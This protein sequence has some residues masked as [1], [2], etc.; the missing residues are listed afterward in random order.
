MARLVVDWLR[1]RNKVGSEGDTEFS[2]GVLL[3]SGLIAG[4]AIA[5]I[6]IA[7]LSLWPGVVEKIDLSSFVPGIAADNWTSVIAFALLFAALVFAGTRK[8]KAK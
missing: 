2:P 1:K 7:L 5:G 6:V 4:G 3:S 8:Q